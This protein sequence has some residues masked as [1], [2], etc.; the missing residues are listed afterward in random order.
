MGRKSPLIK[1]DLEGGTAS[2][3]D[4]GLF[5]GMFESRPKSFPTACFGKPR[6]RKQ[7]GPR[8]G[9]V[10]MWVQGG[11]VDW[12]YWAVAPVLGDGVKALG[13]CPPLAEG[14]KAARSWVSWGRPDE[15]G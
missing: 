14:L 1:R 15:A 3:H 11:L 5:S 7:P 4:P 10:S 9:G 2:V 8:H 12:R 13:P 6:R